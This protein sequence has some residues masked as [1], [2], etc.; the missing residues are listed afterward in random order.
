MFSRSD[1]WLLCLSTYLTR[2]VWY[3]LQAA[4]V[5]KVVYHMQTEES[6]GKN[7]RTNMKVKDDWQPSSFGPDFQAH[8]A[9]QR[10]RLGAAAQNHPTQEILYDLAKVTS[11]N[12]AEMMR[13]FD[14]ARFPEN[15][16]SFMNEVLHDY[17]KTV[18]TESPVLAQDLVN[19]AVYYGL[20]SGKMFGSTV[21][22]REWS[23]SRRGRADNV[24][25]GGSVSSG[26]NGSGPSTERFAFDPTKYSSQSLPN[27]ESK[28]CFS[29]ANVLKKQGKLRDGEQPPESC[30]FDSFGELQKHKRS[31][32]CLA[33]KKK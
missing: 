6:F 14:M 28:L 5:S 16:R 18:E 19:H 11:D 4:R 33:S 3:V 1:C 22:P 23:N 2:G 10:K 20:K 31:G 24:S 26:A 9:R 8:H 17:M 32:K 12:I 13:H 27:A 25:G 30:F 7:G 15:S 29:C 21:S